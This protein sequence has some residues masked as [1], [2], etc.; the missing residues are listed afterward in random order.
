MNKKRNIDIN[1]KLWGD[2]ADQNVALPL[3]EG[4]GDKEIKRVKWYVGNI[5]GRMIEKK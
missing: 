1:L 5:I 3:T 2:A 4:I